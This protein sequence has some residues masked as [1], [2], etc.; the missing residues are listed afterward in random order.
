MDNVT[1]LPHIGS[2]TNECRFDVVI[3]LYENIQ[4]FQ[5]SG[6]ARDPV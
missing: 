6:E 2:A 3:R 4:Q 5:E 1:L